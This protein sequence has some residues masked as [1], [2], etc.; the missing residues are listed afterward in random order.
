MGWYAVAQAIKTGRP[1]VREALRGECDPE[2]TLA[3]AVREILA[4]DPPLDR[5]GRARLAWWR[6]KAGL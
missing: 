4:E 6:R 3:V 2:R 5:W 1:K